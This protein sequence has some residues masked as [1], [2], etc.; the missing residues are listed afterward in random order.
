MTTLADVAAAAGVSKAAAS[1]VLSGKSE[2]RVAERK[3]ERVRTAAD[4]L[5]YVRDALAGGMRNG[6]TRTIGVIGERVLS[7]PYAVSMIDALLST[8]QELGWSVLLTDSGRDGVAAENAVREM[9]ARRVGTVVIATMYH[10]VVDVPEQLD[11][12]VVLNGEAGTPGV[13]GVVPDEYQGA[14]DAVEH[15]IGLGHTRIGYV[16]HDS[17]GTIAVRLREKAFRET[18]AGHGLPV[19]E[20]VVVAGGSDPLSADESAR[21][22]LDR[23]DRPSAI[24]C[25]NDGLAAGVYRQAARL[26]LSVPRDLSVVGFDDLTLISTNLDPLLT[27]MR[28]PHWEMGEWLT[29]ELAAGRARELPELILFPCPLIERASTA[30]PAA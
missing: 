22:L 10:R 12:V 17:R 7:T 11:D 21:R 20:S 6:E 27:T 23:P 29:R 16:S 8:S 24:V 14:R 3:A 2:G 19:D 9:V 13:P 5:G 30:P 25:Y 15:L 26:G 4:E 28:L 1:L 18:M